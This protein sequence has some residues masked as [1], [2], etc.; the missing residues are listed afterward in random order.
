MKANEILLSKGIKECPECHYKSDFYDW[1]YVD[2]SNKNFV[3]CPQCKEEIYVGEQN[4][5][6]HL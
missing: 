3:K 6:L 1:E 4:E 2:F 5:N